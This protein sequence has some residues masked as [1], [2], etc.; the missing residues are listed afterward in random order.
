MGQYDFLRGYP[1]TPLNQENFGV[2]NVVLGDRWAT[3]YDHLPTDVNFEGSF[4]ERIAHLKKRGYGNDMVN[5]WLI[6]GRRLIHENNERRKE[7]TRIQQEN[8]R[9]QAEKRKQAEKIKREQEL[10]IKL[11]KEK[12]EKEQK[13]VIKKEKEIKDSSIGIGVGILVVSILGYFVLK[14]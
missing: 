9:I 6:E 7:A 13:I 2:K 3:K 1:E 4:D 11:I 14:K 10:K 5:Y 8:L 12:Q